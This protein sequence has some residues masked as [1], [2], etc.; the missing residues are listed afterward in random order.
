[1]LQEPKKSGT[2]PPKTS[3][4][5]PISG[6]KANWTKALEASKAPSGPFSWSNSSYFSWRG[7][8]L[9]GPNLEIPLML[10]W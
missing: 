8:K 9:L 1:M 3:V 5:Y 2:F 4:K 6:V 10:A 7:L